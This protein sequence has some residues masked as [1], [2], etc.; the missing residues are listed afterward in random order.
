VSKATE[1]AQL[2]EA[3]RGAERAAA[4]ALDA[5]RLAQESSERAATAAAAAH[6]YA[7]AAREA[8]LAAGASDEIA[9]GEASMADVNATVANVMQT[10]ALR[11]HERAD[12]QVA[13]TREAFQQA[14]SPGE[15]PV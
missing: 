13:R 14:T 5:H 4:V 15:P 7:Q 6:A 12:D 1:I 9:Q 3:W 11:A 10:D 2:L 8:L